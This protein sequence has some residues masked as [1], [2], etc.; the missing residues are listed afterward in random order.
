MNNKQTELFNLSLPTI[1]IVP[2]TTKTHKNYN[3]AQ[4]SETQT[5]MNIIY[6]SEMRHCYYSLHIADCFTVA[7]TL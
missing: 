6:I 2:T 3:L 7:E 4:I 1:F 5:P